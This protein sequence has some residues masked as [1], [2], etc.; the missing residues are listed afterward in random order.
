MR[1]SKTSF[2]IVFVIAI[3]A[4]RDFAWRGFRISF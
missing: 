4:G 3:W 1:W 2:L